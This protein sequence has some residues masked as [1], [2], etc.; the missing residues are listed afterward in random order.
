MS[1]LIRILA[2]TGLGT[3]L[4]TAAPPLSSALPAVTAGPVRATVACPSMYSWDSV[5]DTCV[6]PT[7]GMVRPS[8]Q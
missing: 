8:V 7:S 3:V 2:S 1:H 5:N 4:L 6:R